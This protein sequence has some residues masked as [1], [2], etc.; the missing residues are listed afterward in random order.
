[1]KHTEVIGNKLVTLRVVLFIAISCLISKTI[2]VYG[3][4]IG[5]CL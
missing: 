1:M 4:D 2:R 5:K 3:G